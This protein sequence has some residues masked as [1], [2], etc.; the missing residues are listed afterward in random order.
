MIKTDKELAYSKEWAEKFA[1]ANRKI[2]AN[3]EKRLN[4][5]DGWQLS[6]DSNDALRKKLLDEITEYEALVAH[7]PEQPIMLEIENLDYL[8]DLLIKARIAMKLTQKELAVFC[9]R[10]EEEIKSFEDKNYH[11]ASFLDFANAIDVLGIKLVK[12]KFVA[13][14]DDFYKQRLMNIRRESHL[15]SD[16]SGMRTA[17]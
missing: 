12:G 14:M 13:E 11:N 17:S 8:P 1:E 4:D 7:D 5:P 2:K 15:D 10:T 3:E 9:Q 16:M 6:Q